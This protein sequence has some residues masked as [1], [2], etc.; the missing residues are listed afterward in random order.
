[1]TLVEVTRLNRPE[2]TGKALHTTR[3]SCSS[4]RHWRWSSDRA[5]RTVA[6][7]RVPLTT[8]LSGC[9]TFAKSVRTSSIA[10][11][12]ALSSARWRS[13]SSSAR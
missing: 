9:G 5:D 3:G 6:Q 4:R 13:C 1:M 11:R 10:S 8:E 12:A 7:A 2:E